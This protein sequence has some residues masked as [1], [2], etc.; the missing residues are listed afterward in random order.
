MDILLSG[1]QTEAEATAYCHK[2]RKIMKDG[3]SVF[4][5]WSTIWLILLEIIKAHGL[6]S[7][8][9]T[10]SLL[11]LQWN[12]STD[13]LSFQP[14]YFDSLSDV[15]TQ[16]KLLSI[17]SQLFDPL[18]FLLP[19]TIPAR[20]FLAELRDTNSDWINRCPF[21]RLTSG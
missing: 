17:A 4:H 18:S 7:Q 20:L 8:S 14:K 19:V 16:Q 15:L 12:S 11:R 9:D 1:S 2:A 21:Q 13:Y 6:Q 3:H 5:Q 10:S